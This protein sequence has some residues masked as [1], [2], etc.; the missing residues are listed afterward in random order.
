VKHF[1]T[2]LRDIYANRA[3]IATLT[4][5][6]IKAR[7]LGSAF[8]LVWAFVQPTVTIFV[9][10]FV[11]QFGLKSPPVVDFPFS[12]WLIAGMTPWF[13]FSE[14]FSSAT[15][16]VLEYHYL[17]KNVSVRLSILPIVK[18]LTGLTIHCFLVALMLCI[19]VAYSAPLGVHAVQIAYYA[20]S[21]IVLLLGLSWITSSVVLFVRDVGQAV[22]ISLQ[23]GFW[24]TPIILNFNLV[25]AKYQWLLR[26]NPAL[27]LVEGFRDALIYKVWFWERPLLTVYYWTFTGLVFCAGAVLFRRLRPHFADVI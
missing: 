11:F 7:Y 17:V 1:F 6:D 4:R 19:F 23:L 21:A 10:W 5:R 22:S 20:V 27:Y 13:F 8:G 9:M 18:I 2:F 12:L 3:L 14:S 24:L 26:L 16:S 15:Y 25:P